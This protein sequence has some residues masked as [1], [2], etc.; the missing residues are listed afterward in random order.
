MKQA[1][2]TSSLYLALVLAVLILPA[3]EDEPPSDYIPVPYLEG[4][5]EVGEP[6][7]N[8]IVGISQPITSP[9]D[10]SSMMVKDAQV[11]ISAAG[12]DYDLQ[13]REIDNVG[14]YYFPDTT[15]VVQPET[16]YSIRVRM[17]DGATMSAE[18]VT[19][20][21]I[22]WVIPPRDVLQ[23]PQDTT[24]LVSPDSLRISWTKGNSPEYLVRAR[25]LDTLRYGWY[26]QPPTEEIN[27]RTN[28]IPFEDPDDPQFYTS[29]RWGF[30][31]SN[32][33]PT[34]WAAFRWYGRNEVAI[35]ATDKAMNDW[36]KA[37]QW[38]GRSVEYRPEYSNVVGGVGVFGSAS[39]ITKEVFLLKRKR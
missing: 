2:A 33:A 29:V 20:Q 27:E 11:V 22:S 12:R 24:V 19:P 30:V 8:I 17:P 3:C 31:Q 25:V 1:L 34:V 7:R 21:R 4:Y 5:L 9:F 37:T 26:L 13:Y 16:K 39:V 32:Q 28:N 15:V 14:S 6:I 36:F 10:Y 38:G 18:T 35:L 23:Y